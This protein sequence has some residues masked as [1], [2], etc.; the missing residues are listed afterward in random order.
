M[1]K[2]DSGFIDESKEAID[3]VCDDTSVFNEN[4][5]SDARELEGSNSKMVLIL[6]EFLPIDIEK[7]FGS[8]N[9]NS[10]CTS[11][12]VESLCEILSDNGIKFSEVETGVLI[13]DT[14]CEFGIVDS[15]APMSNVSAFTDGVLNVFEA[16]DIDCSNM[17]D[18][19]IKPGLSITDAD[20]EIV[21]KSKICEF[22]VL[23]D[24]DSGCLEEMVNE[25]ENVVEVLTN[26]K[27]VHIDMI[28]EIFMILLFTKVLLSY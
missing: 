3:N 5:L 2:L 10:D 22:S 20:G 26:I 1:V 25:D 18:N 6:S 7:L 21:F 11:E 27:T 16:T 17:S 14:S 4:I 23:H 19:V 13:P 9:E 12:F 24:K 28:V 8:V 15:L